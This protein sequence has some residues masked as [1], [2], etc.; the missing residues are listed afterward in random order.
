MP[1]TRVTRDQF[2]ASRNKVLHK[3]TGVVFT[4]TPGVDKE[5]SHVN[6]SR[7]GDVLP[8]GED[9]SRAEVYRMAATLMQEQEITTE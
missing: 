8:N 5:I 7:C 1:Y 6:W 2:E 9:Y 3:P 4:S